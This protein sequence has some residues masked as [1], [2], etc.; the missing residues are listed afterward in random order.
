MA[1]NW[2]WKRDKEEKVCNSGTGTEVWVGWDSLFCP[3]SY[4]LERKIGVERKAS[5]AV[6]VGHQE[7]CKADMGCTESILR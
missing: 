1:G 5:E 2:S 6:L 3:C 4:V 7:R